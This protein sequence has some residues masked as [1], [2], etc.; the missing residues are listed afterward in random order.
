MDAALQIRYLV[1]WH[2]GCCLETI[3]RHSARLLFIIQRGTAHACQCE[4]QLLLSSER[5][6]RHP[7]SRG[8]TRA[9]GRQPARAG[10]SVDRSQ[11]QTKEVLEGSECHQK[12]NRRSTCGKMEWEERQRE[13]DEARV[14]MV[15]PPQKN[16]PPVCLLGKQTDLELG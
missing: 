3:K 14:Y 12:E 1:A 5:G 11:K 10:T 2:A 7:L 4:R 16:L 15:H 9:C 13:E 8:T 6:N